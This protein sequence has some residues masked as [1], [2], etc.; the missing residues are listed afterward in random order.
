[1]RAGICAIA[2]ES[3]PPGFGE[4]PLPISGCSVFFTN[5]AKLLDYALQ[6]NLNERHLDQQVRE[7]DVPLAHERDGRRAA[8]A[9]LVSRT[10]TSRCRRRPPPGWRARRRRRRRTSSAP[11]NPNR[12][13]DRPSSPTAA[14]TATSAPPSSAG[15]DD[16]RAAA[17]RGATCAVISTPEGRRARA[18]NPRR[19]RWATLAARRGDAAANENAFR[20]FF[21]PVASPSAGA[22]ERRSARGAKRASHRVSV[23]ETR[24]ASTAKSVS[25]FPL[26]AK[27]AQKHAPAAAPPGRRSRRA[28]IEPGDGATVPPR[29]A[30]ERGATA[31]ARGAAYAMGR[32]PAASDEWA[33]CPSRLRAR[34]LSRRSPRDRP[35]ASRSRRARR[36]WRAAND[37]P[38]GTRSRSFAASRR[39]EIA[40]RPKRA[41]R[42]PRRRGGARGDAG[43]GT[44][45]SEDRRGTARPGTMEARGGHRDDLG[46]VVPSRRGLGS[47]ASEAIRGT[48]RRRRPPGD[49]GRNR[50][51]FVSTRFFQQASRRARRPTRTRA[52]SRW[53]GV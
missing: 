38:K 5:T 24:A 42:V 52:V 19:V 27:N 1:M 33:A 35:G 3:S 39:E 32:E 25:P 53:P 36:R 47:R 37:A 13:P 15:T 50:E 6:T 29:S 44:G 31:T 23:E 8:R 16:G 7:D 49:G 28:Q 4:T 30:A 10:R 14:E 45:T 51:R 21:S 26:S 22:G 17:T 11:K 18:R 43:Q 46:G 2:A 40:R 34:R 12:F 9:A 20:R 48:R 41:R